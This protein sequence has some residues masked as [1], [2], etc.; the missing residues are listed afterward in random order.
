MSD[1]FVI[2]DHLEIKLLAYT[3]GLYR[4]GICTEEL[5]VKTHAEKEREG[6]SVPKC[7]KEEGEWILSQ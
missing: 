1:D 4:S 7:E 3:W 6:E 5:S 2:L